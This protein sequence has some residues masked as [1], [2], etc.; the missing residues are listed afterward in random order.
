MSQTISSPEPKTEPN[1]IEVTDLKKHFDNSQSVIDR[2]F[3]TQPNPVRAVD[4]VSLDIRA[5]ETLGLVG[6]SGCGKSTVGKTVLR[7][8][9]A[10][11]GRVEYKGQ[12]VFEMDA[13]GLKAY[14][15]NAQLLFQDP[16]ASIN[17]RMS[18]GDA[19]AEPLRVH[20]IGTETDR[21]QRVR[22]LL[23]KVGLSAEYVDR[24]VHEF[25]GGQC[26]RIGIARALALNPEFIV[27]DEP[28]SALDVSV[29]AQI[30]NLLSDLQAEF[31]FTYLFISHNLSVI[32]Y[33]CDRVAVMYLGEIVEIGP[34]DE[35]FQHPS[36]PYTKALLDNISTAD[37]NERTREKAVL[38]G[39]VPSPRNPPSGCRFRT[40]CP[41]LIPP[42]EYDLRQETWR[43]LMDLR[44]EVE[45][46]AVE[47][48]KIRRVIELQD[49]MDVSWDDLNRDQQI[50]RLKTYYELPRTVPDAKATGIMDTACG[51]ICDGLYGEA[52]TLLSNVFVSPCELDNPELIASTTGHEA[53]CHL[54]RDDDPVDEG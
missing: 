34:V 30:L 41:Q 18:I 8:V 1:I 49:T 40:R 38:A 16:F 52:E 33:V 6:E 54:C 32:N 11:D 44:Q 10:T 39:D 24:Y 27:L 3:R 43:R 45:S 26:Q 5:G 35:I 2:L 47:I 50:D 19:I 20:E 53:A 46:D 25:S 23:E 21:G 9:E 15:R 17:P 12:N 36:H 37:P 4:G 14:R 42:P 51:H 22:E 13:A 31:E 29:Q 7:L 28:V 48:E